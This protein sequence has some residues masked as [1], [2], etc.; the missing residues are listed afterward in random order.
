[1]SKDSDTSQKKQNPPK[2]LQE[3]VISSADILGVTRQDKTIGFDG[4]RISSANVLTGDSSKM[5]A[6]PPPKKS[7][8]KKE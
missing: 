5:V 7:E 4:Q 1:M 6:Q 2:R 8:G 3:A